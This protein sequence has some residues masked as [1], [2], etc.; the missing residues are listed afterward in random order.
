MK[1]IALLNLAFISINLFA[2][3]G[4]IT[5][6]IQ[7]AEDSKGRCNLHVEFINETQKIFT[8]V[9]LYASAIV[10][11]NEGIVVRH[12][13]TLGQKNELFFR[14]SERVFRPGQ[15]TISESDIETSW[16]NARE[17]CSK[18]SEIEFNLLRGY[19]LSKRGVDVSLD[20][21]VE[22]SIKKYS[23]TELQKLRW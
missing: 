14:L 18:I 4:Y 10:F 16:G 11:D 2:Q 12:N 8:E 20:S 21:Y 13:A 3:T 9:T 5:G 15:I 1:N 7:F 17:Q 23:I 6:D 22:K 19:A